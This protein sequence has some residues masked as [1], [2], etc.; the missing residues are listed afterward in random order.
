LVHGTAER[1]EPWKAF[2]L[3]KGFKDVGIPTLGDEEILG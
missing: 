1:Q 3:D 2:L